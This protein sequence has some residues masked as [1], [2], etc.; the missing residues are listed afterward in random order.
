MY[1]TYS[2][3]FVAHKWICSLSLRFS[4]GMAM[5]QACMH[6]SDDYFLRR[7][8]RYKQGITGKVK[9]ISRNMKP[10]LPTI[11]DA[12]LHPSTPTTTLLPLSPLSLSSTHYQLANKL[13][14]RISISSSSSSFIITLRYT[15]ITHTIIPKPLLQ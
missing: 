10:N 1:L 11:L 8:K 2:I 3:R 12:L 7:T 5:M 15:R 6:G 14:F 4:T 13:P 9:Q